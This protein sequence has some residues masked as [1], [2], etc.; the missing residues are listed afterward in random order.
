M[1]HEIGRH[2]RVQRRQ[3]L[4]IDRVEHPA[5]NGLFRCIR[6]TIPPLQVGQLV[7]RDAG[8]S[9]L[10]G[11]ERSVRIRVC[12][13]ELAE[14]VNEIVQGVRIQAHPRTEMPYRRVADGGR[15]RMH[16]ESLDQAAEFARGA[17]VRFHLDVKR[18]VALPYRLV[19]VA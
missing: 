13:P 8:V 2:Q 7:L 10:E 18:V 17:E 11:A 6:H 12:V 14:S 15:V 1:Q 3:V 9:T 4:R 19:L 16:E 5:D